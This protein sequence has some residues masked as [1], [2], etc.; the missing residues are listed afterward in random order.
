M[1]D[2]YPHPTPF[3][4]ET[5]LAFQYF[6]QEKVEIV[7]LETGMGGRLD[8]TNIIKNT[9]IV[10]LT[11]ISMDHAT[12]LGNT[13]EK[14]AMEKVGIIKEGSVVIT[15]KQNRNL[16]PFQ[17]IDCRVADDTLCKKIYR[18]LEKQ[19]FSYKDYADLEISL[20][21]NYQLQNAVLAIE[22]VKAYE[23]LGN[24]VSEQAIR[25]GL[26]EATWPGR[27]SILAKKPYFI[28]DGA[29]NIDAAQ[30]LV[31]TIEFYFTNKRIL[32]I[33]GVLK[34][35]EYE[36]IIEITHHLADQIITITPPNQPRALHALELARAVATYHPKVTAVDSVEEA[37]EISYLLAN[38]E[39]VIIA[40]GSLSYLGRLIKI[41]DS[42]E[43]LR[44]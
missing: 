17:K 16:E 25:K 41:V 26:K 43:R 5:A 33:M 38:K 36:S 14:I 15:T 1:E 31:E 19:R 39:D 20:V 6:L 37:V 11:S 24:R 42:K 44:K 40:F 30:K 22:A 3:E 28:V 9:K 27:F 35:K 34:D 7:V 29:H 23:E 12:Y 13:L 10:V 4:V 8:A 21:G 2:G 32:F 18:S